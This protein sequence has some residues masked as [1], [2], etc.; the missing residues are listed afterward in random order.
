MKKFWTVLRFELNNYF[1]SKGFV[2][3]TILLTLVLMG[4]IIVPTMIP[5]LLENDTASESSADSEDN[6]QTDT[7]GICVKTDQITDVDSLLSGMW[8]NWETYQDGESLKKA[9][10]DKDVQAG[11]ILNSLSDVS[12]VVN[13]KELYDSYQDAFVSTLEAYEKQQY[14]LEKGLTQE[15]IVAAENININVSTD[16]LG[17]DSASNYWY[18]YILIFLL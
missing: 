8:V 6:D 2:T 11:F 10:K 16:I 13:N 4:V 18:T 9:V 12:Y 3:A 14:L 5:G 1:K 7:L 17:K 15:E